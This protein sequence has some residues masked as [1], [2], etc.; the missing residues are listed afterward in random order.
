M[1]D[2]L[3][4][5]FPKASIGVGTDRIVSHAHLAHGLGSQGL[6]EPHGLVGRLAHGFLVVGR[7]SHAKDSHA[8]TRR[9]QRSSLDSPIVAQI[10][11]SRVQ[12]LGRH[13]PSPTRMGRHHH[14]QHHCLLVLFL[15]FLV[16]LFLFVV[17]FVVQELVPPIEF[18]DSTELNS[19]GVSQFGVLSQCTFQPFGLF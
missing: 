2:R 16:A 12:R 11:Q 3:F 9:T 10:L 15:L 17:V 1:P 18:V 4:H 8:K 7:T 6:Q 5:P 19:R 13:W 14:H